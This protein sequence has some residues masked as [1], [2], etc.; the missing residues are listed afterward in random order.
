MTHDW[1]NKVWSKFKEKYAPSDIFNADEAGIFY[2]LTPDKTLKFKGEKHVGG[3]LS[4]ERIM[5][6]V[7][8][9]MD[10][11]EKRKL[12]VI[13]KSK[14]PRCFK[15]IT[16]LPVTYKANKTAW[17]T[18][19]LFEEEV[20]KWD[21][22]LKGR[23]ILLLVDNCPAHP[24][25]SNLQNIELAFLPP[26]MT[27]VLQPM[28]QSVIKSLKGHYRRKL[29]M[30]LVESE[31]KTS[32]NMLHAVNF[33]SKAWEEVKPTT[34]QHSFRHAGLCTN[35]TSD[36]VE[37]E[38]EFDSDDDLPLTEWIQQ[39]NTAGNTVHVQTYIEVD[40]SL[41][42]TA[43]LTD[44]EILDSVRNT[45]DQEQ[46][47]EED[48]TDEPE[49]PSIKEALEAAKLL[50][51]YFLYHQ[52]TSILQDMN[53]IRND[54]LYGRMILVQNYNGQR[55]KIRTSDRNTLDTMF[56]DNRSSGSRGKTLVICCEGNA[57]FYEIG[58]MT[59]PL[60]AGYSALGWNHPGFAGSTSSVPSYIFCITIN[61]VPEFE[62]SIRTHIYAGKNGRDEKNVPNEDSSGIEHD[63]TEDFVQN[64]DC[65]SESEIK[66]SP[67]PDEEKNAVD[68]VLEY[69]INELGY[70]VEDIVLFGWSIGGYTS[71]WAA[72]AYP[73]I[74]ALV[75]IAALEHSQARKSHQ[76]VA[77]LSIENRISNRGGIEEEWILDATFDD[78]L[79]LAKQHMPPFLE[80]V[81]REVIR[82]HVDLHVA[83]LLEKY[84]G[85]VQLI[86]RTNDEIICLRL[87][88]R[89]LER[90]V[91]FGEL[92]YPTHV[93]EIGFESVEELDFH[94][95]D[96]LVV[97]GPHIYT[98][99]SRIEGKI[100]PGGVDRPQ[101]PL[102]H[103]TRRDIS[104]IV[105]EG[106]AARLFWVRAHARITGNEYADELA[107]HAAVTKKTAA[108][109]DKF[110]LSFAKK[111]IRAANLEEWQERYAEGSIGEITEC[112]FPRMEQA[113]KLKDLY[114]ACD[115][116]KTQ[117]VLH[118][119]EECD[120]FLWGRTVLEAE[121]G[122]RIA[123]R[124]FPEILKDTAKIIKLLEFCSLLVKR[125]RNLNSNV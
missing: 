14:N 105:A 58:I 19:Q 20:R 109:Y 52:D 41:L 61:T 53:K 57:G 22:E 18:S 94:T 92:S 122:V 44:Q 32:V 110:L 3:K 77:G 26:N 84:P 85:P 114:C 24:F 2:K 96:C 16:K 115:L 1:I 66:G 33:L 87:V 108:D 7:A 63:V 79:P 78:I 4:K 88:Y 47:D 82:G 8:A 89:E 104:E 13:G 81:V 98:D 29:L 103:E 64:E 72:S 9:N 30:E 86:R 70:N 76:C 35:S 51:N 37:T 117:D 69:A 116:A 25:I 113:F 120:M 73:E 60:K 119:L 56:V 80:P 17:M 83:Q 6:L 91:Y 45:E 12:M 49:P 65:E 39:F 97:V 118:V 99:N 31:G 21:A 11:T 48:E 10:G 67:Y 23:K 112:F 123:R 55:A 40:D 125:C 107:R 75:V 124:H 71:T 90:P 5:V 46:G 74:K 121:I 59:T 36:V 68:A 15:N 28:D 27:S 93:L 43:S 100:S 54:L 101:D 34:I 106:R 50:E 95:L 102:A 62:E 38:P 111:V 42:T